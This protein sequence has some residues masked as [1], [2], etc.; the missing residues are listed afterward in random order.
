MITVAAPGDRGK[1]GTA[2]SG[3]GLSPLLS[4]SRIQSRQRLA[5][6]SL[7]VCE[8]SAEGEGGKGTAGGRGKKDTAVAVSANKQQKKEARVEHNNAYVYFAT[9]F[10]SC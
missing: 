1:R 7:A 5:P 8:S 9:Y 10:L 4:L 2:S 6:A 3:Q